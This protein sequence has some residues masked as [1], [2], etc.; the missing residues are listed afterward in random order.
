MAAEKAAGSLR[1][2]GLRSAFDEVRS[3][4]ELREAEDGEWDEECEAA[5]PALGEGLDTRGALASEV[6]SS[7][8]ASDTGAKSGS[9]EEDAEGLE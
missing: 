1:F 7:E 4:D 3:D 9:D 2:L 5:E 8:S 6:S